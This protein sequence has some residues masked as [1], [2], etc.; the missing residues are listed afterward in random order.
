MKFDLDRLNFRN[1]RLE[2]AMARSV[3]ISV[4]A[5]VRD[6]VDTIQQVRTL[7][8]PLLSC[9]ESV[10]R[11]PVGAAGKEVVARARA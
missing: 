6:F 10:V 5:E 8:S 2:S 11:K 7:G 3:N 4:E 1:Q 9:K